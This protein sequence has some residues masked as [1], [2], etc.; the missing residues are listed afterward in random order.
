MIFNQPE[1]TKTPYSIPMEIL[2]QIENEKTKRDLYHDLLEYEELIT[3]GIEGGWISI[4]WRL[5]LI[6]TLNKIYETIQSQLDQK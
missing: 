3:D 2:H 1:Y 4:D 6:N 5:G